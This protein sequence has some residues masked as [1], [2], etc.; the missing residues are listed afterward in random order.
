MKYFKVNIQKSAVGRSRHTFPEFFVNWS[1][2]NHFYQSNDRKTVCT[3]C[4]LNR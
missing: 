4:D 2:F 1:K 3:F